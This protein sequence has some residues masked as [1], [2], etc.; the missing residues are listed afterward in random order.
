MGALRLG[1]IWLNAWDLWVRIITVQPRNQPT[2]QSTPHQ[3]DQ[4]KQHCFWVSLQLLQ[5]SYTGLKF[6]CGFVTLA[7]TQP[8][9]VCC[10][11]KWVFGCTQNTANMPL[12]NVP[13]H[14]SQ[15]PFISC[16][17]PWPHATCILLLFKS[18]DWQDWLF[19]AFFA[20]HDSSTPFFPPH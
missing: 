16:L 15:F 1:I 4:L 3:S 20:A 12:F 9:F 13:R 8:C 17:A 6:Y 10:A 19:W 14:A 2:K 11:I 7:C 18:V 5:P